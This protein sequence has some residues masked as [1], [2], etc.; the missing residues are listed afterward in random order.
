[1]SNAALM[2]TVASALEKLGAVQAELEA[3]MA[4]MDSEPFKVA[5]Q[6]VYTKHTLKEQWDRTK[7]LPGVQALFEVTASKAGEWVAFSD[8]LAR[9][10]LSPVQQRNEHAR[11]TAVGV[12]IFGERRWPIE[13]WTR[14]SE[15][16][17]TWGE[18]QKTERHYRMDLIIVRWWFEIR[19]EEDGAA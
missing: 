13:Y 3:V 17:S 7:H 4:Q 2:S 11:L 9:S 10:G 15:G 19:D 1:M 5:G 16:R 12:Q 18:E 14:K 8:L 6:G